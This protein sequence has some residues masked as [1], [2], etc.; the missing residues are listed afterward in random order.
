MSLIRILYVSFAP[1]SF[2]TSKI[3]AGIGSSY[4]RT[5]SSTTLREYFA[6]SRRRLF[7]ALLA[8]MTLN[9][10]AIPELF[11]EGFEICRLAL[12]DLLSSPADLLKFFRRRILLRQ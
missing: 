3:A 5:R 12:P 7:L 11:K 2:F 10:Q 8:R 1:A 4:R 9:R 6:C